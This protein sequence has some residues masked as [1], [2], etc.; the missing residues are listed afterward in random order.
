MQRPKTQAVHVKTRLQQS[1]SLY[2][3]R[4]LRSRT[5]ELS[6]TAA[7]YIS[8]T[9]TLARPL[10]LTRRRSGTAI[11]NPSLLAIEHY[12]PNC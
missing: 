12:R 3:F 6:H 7:L 1:R 4:Y 9:L 10:K 2:L 5:Q 11:T 8:T